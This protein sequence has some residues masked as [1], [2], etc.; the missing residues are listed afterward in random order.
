MLMSGARAAHQ[1]GL[2]RPPCFVLN[3]ISCSVF[4]AP[5]G[6]SAETKGHLAV[7]TLSFLCGCSPQALWSSKGLLQ[8]FSPLVFC[9]PQ[10]HDHVFSWLT[11]PAVHAHEPGTLLSSQTSPGLVDGA[12][13]K[14]GSPA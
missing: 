13:F 3:L 8:V 9:M 14:A 5:P 10:F 1:G 4:D 2:D 12:M 7:L 6:D 11:A